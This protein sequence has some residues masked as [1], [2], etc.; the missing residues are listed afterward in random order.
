MTT[1]IIYPDNPF[2]RVVELTEPDGSGSQI[3]LARGSAVTA[4]LAQVIEGTNL[5][6]V[7]AADS[8]LVSACIQIG[9]GKNWVVPFT[10]TQL[11]QAMLAKKF[12]VPM[13][14]LCVANDYPRRVNSATTLGN[15]D[16]GQPWVPKGGLWGIKNA[17]VGVTFGSIYAVSS[18]GTF[19]DGSSGVYLD[20]GAPHLT[21]EFKILAVGK[22][23]GIMLGCDATL[24]NFLS[25][26]AAPTG[27]PGGHG[28]LRV[29][30]KINDREV[31]LIVAD[32]DWTG[33][34][35]V[36]ALRD[37]INSTLTVRINGVDQCVV[38]ID[39]SVGP[40]NN[41][42][43]AA[44]DNTSEMNGFVVTTAPVA[45]PYIV[46]TKPSGLRQ[47]VQC[48]YAPSKGAVV[49]PTGQSIAVY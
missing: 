9:T 6:T 42:G 48:S 12:G 47:Y 36:T 14:G 10:P 2:S 30:Q 18:D 46:I 29:D 26:L 41:Y 16:S 3:P 17:V 21:V 19:V 24:E 8:S 32:Y 43:F 38:A 1:P 20:A 13:A 15:A 5:E 27:G 49:A 39:P 11:T 37:L 40:T 4:F 33:T 23:C 35:T 7:A 22:V 45:V 28:R 25:V 34:N 44:G 31:S